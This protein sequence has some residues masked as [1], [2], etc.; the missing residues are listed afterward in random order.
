MAK[1][2]NKEV[3]PLS[4]PFCNSNHVKGGK[5]KG[6]QRYICRNCNRHFFPDAKHPHPKWKVEQVLRMYSNGMSMRAISRVLE[7]PLSTVFAWIKRHGKKRFVQLVRLWGDAR[8]AANGKVITQRWSMK[9]GP[10][11]AGT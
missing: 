10:I 9:C 5:V 7:V 3:E 6:R 2:G 8:Q 11:C 4:C 1:R